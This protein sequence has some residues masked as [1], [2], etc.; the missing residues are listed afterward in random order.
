[1]ALSIAALSIQSGRVIPYVLVAGGGLS[2]TAVGTSGGMKVTASQNGFGYYIGFGGGASIYAGP[3]WGIRPEFRYERQHFN[4]TTIGGSPI[5]AY[6]QN[7]I[8][9]TVSV[10][11]QF[12]GKK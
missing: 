3:N 6:S 11:Y 9:G 5:A 1:M 10:F 4:S 7:Y 2:E 12:G 8:L